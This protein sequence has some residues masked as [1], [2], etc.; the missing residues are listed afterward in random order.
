MIVIVEEL[1]PVLNIYGCHSQGLFNVEKCKCLV[2]INYIRR[3]DS[4]KF[5]EVINSV[6]F[7]LIW[8]K[9][10]EFHFGSS[11]PKYYLLLIFPVIQFQVNEN[12]VFRCDGDSDTASFDEE[13]I[14]PPERIAK[15]RGLLKCCCYTC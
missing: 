15:V 13:S 2:F 3:C 10:L 1:L 4:G 7:S 8:E 5:I 12:D 14:K 9:N 6:S 11:A